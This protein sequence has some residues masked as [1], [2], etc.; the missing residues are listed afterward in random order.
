MAYASNETGRYEIY[1]RPFPGAGGR[2]RIS[3]GGGIFPR[4]RKDGRELFYVT[5]DNRL[6]A[7]PVTVAPAGDALGLGAPV[8][9]FPTRIATGVS[10]SSGGIFSRA[11]YALA[12][13]GRFLM[14]VAADETSA[15]PISIIFNWETALK[16]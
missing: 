4:W 6:M 5:P 14:N 1:A 8:V 15:S 7:V 3:S 12:S 2:L 11:Q 16:K 10:N 13:D 9:L